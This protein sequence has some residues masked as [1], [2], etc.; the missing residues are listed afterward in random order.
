MLFLTLQVSFNDGHHDV[1]Y[2]DGPHGYP[3]SRPGESV[4]LPLMA[5]GQ[6]VESPR[7]MKATAEIRWLSCAATCLFSLQDELLPGRE[8]ED[9]LAK[10]KFVE[11]IIP[12]LKL[13]NSTP[14]TL[15]K[16]LPSLSVFK[17][18]LFHSVYGN[19]LPWYDSTCM[20]LQQFDCQGIKNSCDICFSAHSAIQ[21]KGG[22]KFVVR[23][24][25]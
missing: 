1:S 13:W 11:L 19:Y 20:R 2:N 21:P 24:D 8:F 18:G 22:T 3:R 10:K 12:F 25:D 14:R 6:D 7:Q 23:R 15:T 16:L 17:F 4:A 9:L 5:H